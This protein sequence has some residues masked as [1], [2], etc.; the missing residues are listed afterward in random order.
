MLC[1]YTSNYILVVKGCLNIKKIFIST[2]L[3]RFNMNIYTKMLLLIK[4]I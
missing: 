1:A 3:K 2:V 4:I